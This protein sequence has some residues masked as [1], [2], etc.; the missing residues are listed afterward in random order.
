MAQI[1]RALKEAAGK[2]ELLLFGEA[3]LQGFDSLKFDFETDRAVA[4]SRDSETME[5]LKRL[6]KVYGAALLFGYIEREGE[7]VYSSCALISGGEL[8]HNY[9]RVS[10]GWKVPGADAHYR[11]GD[12]TK[13]FRFGGEDITIALCGDLWDSP[14]RF[15]TGGLLIWPV[16]LNYTPAE[17]AEGVLAEYAEHANSVAPRALMI[18]PL[19]DDPVSY[20]GA[21]A[22][23]GGRAAAGTKFGEESI[24]IVDTDELR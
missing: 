3:F 19:D 11:E 14:G 13:G 15:N 22:F 5:A 16:Y 24:L 2:A 20:G 10:A 6:T 17:W 8:V 9:R 1:E 12:D 7:A 4:V 21:F 18:N 23:V